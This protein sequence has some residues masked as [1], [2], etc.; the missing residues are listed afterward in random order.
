MEIPKR[1]R[2]NTLG[3]RYLKGTI[4]DSHYDMILGHFLGLV[5]AD[6]VALDERDN[7]H[8][9]FKVATKETYDRI[10]NEK[11][12]ENIEV[13]QNEA[14]AVVEDI[15]S[16]RTK[17]LIRNIP[18]EISC[19]EILGFLEDYGEIHRHMYTIKTENNWYQDIQTG[20]MVVMMELHKAIPS[21]LYI[22]D[23]GSYVEVRYDQQ[24]PTCNSCGSLSHKVRF[25]TTEFGTGSNVVEI[26]HN[27]REDEGENSE[28]NEPNEDHETMQ[29]DQLIADSD[30]L[31]IHSE[32][33]ARE[34]TVNGQAAVHT[35]NKDIA[36]D[37]NEIENS[38]PEQAA[39]ITESKESEKEICEND[40]THNNA[41]A[42]QAAAAVRPKDVR[43]TKDTHTEETNTDNQKKP[44]NKVSERRPEN[45]EFYTMHKKH[46]CIKCRKTL[47]TD[48]NNLPFSC[49]ACGP[50]LKPKN[51]TPTH[52]THTE[53]NPVKTSPK[54]R[55]TTK[56]FSDAVKTP[57]IVSPRYTRRSAQR[58]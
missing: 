4:K 36:R 19:D 55:T 44:K 50:D 13:G 56:T 24:P 41:E 37:T 9:L 20:R 53:V 54:D 32:T 45:K 51:N 39:A 46:Y 42:G 48:R 1:K 6:I 31:S 2:V 38:K 12:F 47:K 30:T 58:F 23:V 40:T 18:F 28:Q 15:S 11:T 21:T 57:G 52:G 17:V 5:K 7:M 25:C 27:W 29:G 49:T 26:D 8:I 35:E 14:I 3:I 16:Y 10:C 33:S 34:D 43:Y 22:K